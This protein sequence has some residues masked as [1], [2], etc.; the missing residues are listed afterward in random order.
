MESPF[1]LVNNIGDT[2]TG[3]VRGI[4]TGITGMAGRLNSDI[5]SILDKPPIIGKYGPHKAVDKLVSGT[6]SSIN[7]AG[8]GFVG[9]IQGEG[10]TVVGTVETPINQLTGGM[11]R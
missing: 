5:T 8:N 1:G 7:T 2:V 3:V 11:K 4:G 6:L 10:H 9:G